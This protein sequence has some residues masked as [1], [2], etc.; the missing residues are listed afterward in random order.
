MRLQTVFLLTAALSFACTGKD[1]TRTADSRRATQVD[2][3]ARSDAHKAQAF[4]A[5]GNE[6]FWALLIDSKGLHFTT[7]DD[8]KGIHFP[9]LTPTA[10]G[11]TLNWA[12]ETERAAVIVRIWPGNC[13]DGMS[14]RIWPYAAWVHIDG[15]TYRG[16]AEGLRDTLSAPDPIGEWEVVAHRIPGISAMTDKEAASWHGRTVRL[17]KE[18]ASSNTE[19]C[20]PPVYHYRMVPGDS[21]FAA[22]HTSVGAL[23]LEGTAPRRLGL[24]EVFCGS[25]PWSAMGSTLIWIAENRPLTVWDGVF[26]ELRRSKDTEFHAGPR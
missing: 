18:E 12:G 5:I 7:P 26:F 6:P 25:A 23:Q 16:C 9:P 1:A 14:D 15:M 19:P 4:R 17:G 2:T 24:T 20:R 13:S 10:R 11:D 21:L 22:F 3:A 8:M